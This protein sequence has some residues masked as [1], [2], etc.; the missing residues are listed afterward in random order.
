MK[1][2]FAIMIAAA[3]AMPEVLAIQSGESTQGSEFYFSFM[4]GRPKREKTMTLF[5]S[6]EVAGK[7]E[8]T[9]PRTGTTVTHNINVQ[10]L[11]AYRLF[12][13]RVSQRLVQ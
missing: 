5:V 4:R 13:K 11:P 9:N 12:L 2:I 7:L 6:S 10:L 3:M 8:L 1:K